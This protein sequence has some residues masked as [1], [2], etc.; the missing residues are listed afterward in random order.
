M[1]AADGS[2]VGG[3]ERNGTERWSVEL[4]VRTAEQVC[5]S[6]RRVA[7]IDSTDTLKKP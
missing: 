4:C 5:G 6:V 2:L 3:E 7:S 1:P